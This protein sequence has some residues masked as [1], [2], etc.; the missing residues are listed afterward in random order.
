MHSILVLVSLGRRIGLG[1]LI[2]DKMGAKRNLRVRLL[3][4]LLC[5]PVRCKSTQLPTRLERI[6]FSLGSR[7][8]L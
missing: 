1:K 2:D 6:S 3:Y 8:F 5:L 4:L 7:F